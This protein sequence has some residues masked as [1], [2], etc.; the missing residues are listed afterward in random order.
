L[1]HVANVPNGPDEVFVQS[2]ASGGRVAQ[3]SAKGGTEPRWSPDG[4][5]L[6]YLQ[7]DQLISVPVES[8][9]TLAVGKAVTLLTGVPVWSTDSHQT[10]HVAPTGDRFLMMRAADERGAAPEVR[11]VF[12]W[13]VELRR[14]VSGNGRSGSN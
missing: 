8:G 6:Y 12:N 7:D 14:T 2:V 4:R 10:Y 5:A 3:I 1:A 11:A 9:A 13:F